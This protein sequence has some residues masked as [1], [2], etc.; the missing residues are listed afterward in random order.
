VR[1]IYADDV[2]ELHKRRCSNS[3]TKSDNPSTISL[4]VKPKLKLKR[5]R[6]SIS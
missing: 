5:K 4:E 2:R 3:L 6:K 1:G